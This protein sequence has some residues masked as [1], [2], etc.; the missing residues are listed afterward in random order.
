MSGESSWSFVEFIGI[1]LN[2]TNKNMVSE[3][4]SQLDYQSY[5][6][7]IEDDEVV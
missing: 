2:Q 5:N 6:Y 3:E 7:E 1:K 4:I